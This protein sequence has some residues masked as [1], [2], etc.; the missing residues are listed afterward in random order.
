M[1]QKM[2]SDKKTL[3]ASE[4]LLQKFPT[5]DEILFRNHLRMSKDQFEV[6]LHRLPET[7]QLSVML[8]QCV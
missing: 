8:Y 5:E 6:L 1:G 2:D 4:C 7:T 3:G